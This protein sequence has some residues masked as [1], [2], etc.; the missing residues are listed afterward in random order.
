[1]LMVDRLKNVS[2]HDYHVAVKRFNSRAASP[3]LSVSFVCF[4]VPVLKI[5]R[6]NINT[7]SN[8]NGGRRLLLHICFSVAPI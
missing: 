6:R 4:V 1:M 7:F 5:I 8:Q 2:T 3:E